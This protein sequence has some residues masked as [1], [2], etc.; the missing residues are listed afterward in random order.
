MPTAHPEGLARSFFKA[1]V[2][3]ALTF[4]L[5]PFLAVGF[6]RYGEAKLD[7][8]ILASISA[9][10]E[11]DATMSVEEKNRAK[12]FFAEHPASAACADATPEAQ[13]YREAVCGPWG[14]VWQFV[15]AE[16]VALLAAI[17][18]IAALLGVG[19]LG[20]VAFWNR[21][22][23]YWSFM[24]GWR[25]LVAV[26][27]LETIAQGALLVWLSYWVTALLLERYSPK[28]ILVAALAAGAAVVAIVAALLRKLPADAPLEA[29]V[30]AEADAP[31]LYA[32]VR[33]LAERLGT[34]PPS[35]IA[36]GVD[37]NFFVTE[38][39]MTLE[40][41]AASTGR[42]LYVSLPL[43][44]TLTPAEADA[45]FGHEL[46][47]F[48]GGDTA[49]S[50]RLHPMLVRYATYAAGL[51][52]GG[53]TKPA[54]HVM[55][56]YRAIFELAL[57]RD[58]RRRELLADAEAARL[59]SPGD[60]GRALLKIVG[61]SSFRAKIEQELFE[62]RS[63]HAGGLALAARVD[64]G[65]A[66]Y[67]ASPG[68]AEHVRTTEVPHPFDSHPPLEERLDAV[69]AGAR[70]DEAAEL[71]RDRPERTWADDVLT[72]PR[73]EARLWAAYES[74]FR[75]SHE[76]SLA[77]RYL[78]ETDAERE[79]VLRFFPE[80]VFPV[81]QGGAVR[82]TYLELVRADGAAMPLS[83]IEGAKI[84]SGTFSASLV[85]TRRAGSDG[86]RTFKVPLKPL[87]KA[88]EA[89]KAAFSQYWQR[90]QVARRRS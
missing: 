85:L 69:S 4:L 12:A 30:L 44:R 66:A 90:D 34:T 49:A 60:L 88:A 17:L 77:W 65:L 64:E 86:E 43:L 80:Q 24:L 28:L 61:Y 14:E 3:P 27:V 23:Q 47:H 35:T 18:G 84:D 32:R 9:D 21:G 19:A 25:A 11:R 22:A 2:L 52:S 7:G 70:I 73:I 39:P 37:D 81:K 89:F 46:A 31:G 58:S 42:F 82:L 76:E 38:H 10:I 41:G 75:A 62:E 48:K 29:D 45:V 72:A 57:T 67:A 13:R 56:L 71:L 78:P 1:L 36:A 26:T 6:A 55:R 53:L 51:A 33:E 5:V 54:A 8:M 68:F 20:L 79:H 74:R 15:A 59:T 50:A 87:G 40:G 16:R 63:A 83:E